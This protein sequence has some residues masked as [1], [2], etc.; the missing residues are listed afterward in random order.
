[1]TD[2]LSEKASQRLSQQGWVEREVLRRAHNTNS[3]GNIIE[4]QNAE[5]SF[6]SGPATIT[7][8][9]STQNYDNA[10]WAESAIIFCNV[11]SIS[12]TVSFKLNAIDW[13]SGGT[14]TLGTTSAITAAGMYSIQVPL[15]Y[16]DT[17]NVSYSGAITSAVVTISGVF[18]A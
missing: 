13:L 9:G 12:G 16:G 14:V 10:G 8:A 2:N 17:F 15:L 11:T 7:A 1:M 5:V 18:K 6:T 3:G 4:R